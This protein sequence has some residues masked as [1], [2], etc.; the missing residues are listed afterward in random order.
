MNFGG[1]S[2]SASASFPHPPRLEEEYSLLCL[3]EETQI[4][5]VSLLCFLHFLV[6]Q[7]SAWTQFL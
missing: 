3:V 6:Y 2:M 7:S 5:S 4:L 1:S